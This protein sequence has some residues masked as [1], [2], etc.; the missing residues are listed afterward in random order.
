MNA[1]EMLKDALKCAIL[2]K[3]AY[4]D[5]APRFRS[6]TFPH[7]V[8]QLVEGR[9]TDTQCLILAEQIAAVTQLFIVFRGSDSERDWGINLNCRQAAA[10]YFKQEVVK[11]AILEEK[12]QVYPYPGRSQSGAKMHQGFVDA[13]ASVRDAIHDV[14]QT[15]PATRV[16]V[17]GHSLGGAVATLCAVDLQYNF[18]PKFGIL[19]AHAR[20]ME[21]TPT[22]AEGAA[23]T[24]D[25]AVQTA[26]GITLYTFGSPRVGNGGFRESFNRRV[27]RSFRFVYGMDLV[28]T[29]PRPWQNYSH[30]DQEYRLGQRLRFDFITRRFQDHKI[31]NYIDALRAEAR[32]AGVLEAED[33]VG[34]RAQ[35][36]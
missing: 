2:S 10:E 19:S 29:F 1:N 31:E 13:Y 25:G 26:D 23:Q 20:A 30:V 28:P 22:S 24:T 7:M 14:I 9:K 8:P 18:G 33:L 15:H 17:A 5:F 3:E 35:R 16:A 27:P 6:R 21:P 34:V 11:E 12:R 36:W 32:E 4:G